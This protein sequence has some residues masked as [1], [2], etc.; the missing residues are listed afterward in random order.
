MSCK[1]NEQN[2]LGFVLLHEQELSLSNLNEV[3]QNITKN[4]GHVTFELKQ[5]PS[6]GEII[7]TFYELHARS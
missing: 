4:Y 6:S 1:C 3:K 2:C 5:S 7:N